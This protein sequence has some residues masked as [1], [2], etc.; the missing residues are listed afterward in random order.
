MKGMPA[1][2]EL[3]LFDFADQLSEKRS[4]EKPKQEFRKPMVGD[5][6]EIPSIGMTGTI[7]YI[8]HKYLYVHQFHPIQ[9]EL[10]VAHE[11]QIIYRTNLKDMRF[12]DEAEEEM[13][14]LRS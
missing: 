7:D 10:D 3:D 6:V 11:G 14:Y 4:E 9:V 2:K 1:M 5:R 13:K 12:I 8:S